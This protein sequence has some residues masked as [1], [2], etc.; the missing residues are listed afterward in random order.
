MSPSE[1]ACSFAT[2]TIGPRGAF[3]GYVVGGP[4]RVVSQPCTRRASFSSTSSET[5]PP[6]L[7]RTSTT[8]ASRAT[9]R[10]QVPVQLGPAVG[11]HVRDVQVADAAAGGLVRRGPPV[12]HPGLVAQGALVLE[13]DHDHPADLGPVG[14]P[15]GQLDRHPGGAGQQRRRPR[16]AGRPAA[17]PRP[18]SRRRRGTATPGRAQRR[19]GAAHRRLARQHPAHQPAVAGPRQ[20]GA[21]VA[22]RPA[23]LGRPRRR[24]SRTRGSCP[25]R[26]APP[27]A[28]RT[29]R[30]G[31]PPGPPA[32]GSAP[33]R[34]PSRR[35]PCR[36]S[37]SGRASAGRP[38]RTSAATARP[39]RPAP[40]AGAGRR[41]RPRPGRRRRP[42]RPGGRPAP[43]AARARRAPAAAGRRR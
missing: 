21:Q 27:R 13:R 7:S 41:R 43:A 18:G 29:G 17:R 35:R 3:D 33:A 20:V 14:R 22:E 12:G 4:C 9:S 42:G 8:S 28:A 10:M 2:A 15:H 31:W 24:R 19:A 32:A 1:P 40:A 37:R 30:R 5:W 34:R 11:H 16:A 38:R 26:P 39:G 6:L 36:R 25:A 23:R